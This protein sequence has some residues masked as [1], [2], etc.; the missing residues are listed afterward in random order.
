MFPENANFYKFLEL[1]S[2][3]PKQCE[4]KPKVCKKINIV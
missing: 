2:I 3:I 1:F 4:K